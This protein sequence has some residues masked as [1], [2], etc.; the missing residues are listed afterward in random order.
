MNVIKSDNKYYKYES[1]WRRKDFIKDINNKFFPKPEKKKEK[2][3][4]S[5]AFLEK[6]KEIENY[7]R[8]KNNYI[9][10]NKNNYTDCLICNKKNVGKGIFTINRIRWENS[11]DHYIKEHNIKPSKEFIDMVFN[12]KRFNF[13]KRSIG[14]LG[15]ELITAKNKRMIKINRN[16]LNIMDALMEHGGYS[17]RYY[18]DKESIF[19]YSEHAGMLDFDFKELNK[20]IIYGSTNRTS[21]SDKDIFLPQTS[22]EFY[23]YEYIFHTHPPTPY[24]GGRTDVG[25]L[26]EFPSISDLFHFI[27]HYN[28]G[29]TQ[30]SIIMTPEGLYNIRKKNF[31]NKKIIIN[32]KD[33]LN[34]VR[35]VFIKIQINA[36]NKYGQNIPLEK[37]YTKVSQNISYI[38]EF[39]KILNT[40]DINVDYYPRKKIKGKWIIDTIHIPVYPNI[41]K[42]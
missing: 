10:Y 4:D 36:I 20:I 32:K 6:L 38:K 23:D 40:Y 29:N 11:L 42:E 24:P 7:I 34:K 37:F 18:D 33:F 30:G 14:K 31:D 15:A 26:Y 27:E 19:K 9:I 28:N 12:F 16:Q 22:S 21:K 25:I 39:N 35:R 3:Y 2:W 17:K 5:K 41:I 1:F 13:L 8:E